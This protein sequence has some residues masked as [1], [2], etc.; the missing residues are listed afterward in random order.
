M[1]CL[2]STLNPFPRLQARLAVGPSPLPV[3]TR[4]PI[5]MTFQI[6]NHFNNAFLSPIPPLAVSE[7]NFHPLVFFPSTA[8]VGWCCHPDSCGHRAVC[9]APHGTDSFRPR[10]FEALGYCFFKANSFPSSAVYRRHPLCVETR[11]SRWG[12]THPDQAVV[13]RA[14]KKRGWRR[15]R[16]HRSRLQRTN[17]PPAFPRRE[18]RFSPQLSRLTAAAG[19]SLSQPRLRRRRPR[20]RRLPSTAAGGGAPPRSRERRRR[21]LTR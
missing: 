5:L 18:P 14:F 9:Y 2:T 17:P 4:C 8:S 16:G 7:T 21:R 11:P 1:H 15:E 6:H 19:P 13:E 20:M 12:F 10:P 3:E